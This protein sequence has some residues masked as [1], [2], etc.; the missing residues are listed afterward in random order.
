MAKET[1]ETSLEKASSK[2]KPENQVMKDM[3]T[4]EIMKKIQD[5]IADNDTSVLSALKML[6]A[7]DKDK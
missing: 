3:M 1:K 2:T 4:K 6:L 5:K 7:Q